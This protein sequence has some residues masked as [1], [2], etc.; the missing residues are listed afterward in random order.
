MGDDL[1][2][3]PPP[4]KAPTTWRQVFEQLIQETRNGEVVVRLKQGEVQAV[5]RNETFYFPVSKGLTL[6][7]E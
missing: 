5:G 1:G 4:L 3:S 2:V 6:P 7:K